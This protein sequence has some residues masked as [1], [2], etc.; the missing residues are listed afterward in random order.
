MFSK[1][2]GGQQALCACALSLSLQESFPSPIIFYDE[3][4]ASLDTHN[5]E[6]LAKL[7]QKACQKC[8]FVCISLRHQMYE[9]ARKL[10]GVYTLN[11]TSRTVAKMFAE[12]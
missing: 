7:L 5:T 12:D 3:I 1:L 8:Q 10:I 11:G 6:K 4:D 9:K 2:S